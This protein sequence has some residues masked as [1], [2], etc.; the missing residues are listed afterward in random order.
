MTE[1]DKYLTHVG[2][3]NAKTEKS[4]WAVKEK[5]FSVHPRWI[6]AA[7]ILWEKQPEEKF[8]V[9]HRKDKT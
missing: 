1:V 6:E 5:K 9:G 4:H 7:N 3:V 2:S 8:P